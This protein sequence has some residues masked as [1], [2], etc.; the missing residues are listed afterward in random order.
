MACGYKI[1]DVPHFTTEGLN[2]QSIIRHDTPRQKR[3]VRSDWQALLRQLDV[4][5]VENPEIHSCVGL[6]TSHE[7]AR[8]LGQG[9]A[10]D[11]H[12]HD[13]VSRDGPSS[14]RSLLS[15]TYT[16]HIELR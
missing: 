13:E 10:Q 5:G 4:L 8:G 2:N 16:I 9:G 3:K 12:R 6:D 14:Q 15:R 1:Q 11:L 7:T